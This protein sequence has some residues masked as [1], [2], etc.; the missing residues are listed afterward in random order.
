MR[1]TLQSRSTGAVHRNSVELKAKGKGTMKQ[2][3]LGAT[4]LSAIGMTP[5]KAQDFDN[6]EI[7]VVEVRPGVAVLFGRGGNIGVSYGEDGTI[8]VDDQ[9]APLIP[10]ITAAVAELGAE[11]VEYV[12]NT[13]WHFDHTGGNEPLGEAGAIIVA[14]DNVRARLLTGGTVFGNTAPPAPAA[15]L[16]V[17]TYDN[18]MTI[19]ANGDAID[20]MFLGGGHTDGD[21]VV[22]WREANV[23]HLGDLFFHQMGWPFIDVGSGGNA[24]PLLTSLARVIAMIDEETVVIPGHGPVTNRAGLVAYHAMVDEGIRR[25][26]ALRDEGQSLEQIIAA[27]PLAGLSNGPEQVFISDDAFATAVWHSL[28]AHSHNH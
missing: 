16:P 21:T 25:I 11:P 6:V 20:L 27:E 4:L 7:Q 13:H 26:A 10:R 18:G 15:A 14:H 5:V 22:L 19:H 23:V 12:I 17:L 8:L 24:Q 9:F 1:S 3:L 28:E 2:I